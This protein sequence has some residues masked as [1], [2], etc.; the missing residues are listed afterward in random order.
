MRDAHKWDF[1]NAYS[2]R[3]KREIYYPILFGYYDTLKIEIC[4]V[5][6]LVLVTLIF[7]SLVGIYYRTSV[8]LNVA[9]IL[10][11]I[12]LFNLIIK[13][14]LFFVSIINLLKF[15]QVQILQLALSKAFPHPQ[16]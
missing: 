5:N 14:Y 16:K 2:P 6:S 8:I 4:V 13:V 3:V 12:Y 11:F 10:F 1:N 15:Q 7:I 9:I